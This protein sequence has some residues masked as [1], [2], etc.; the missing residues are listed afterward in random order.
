MSPKSQ[1]V[2]TEPGK[3]LAQVSWQLKPTKPNEEAIFKA[4]LPDGTSAQE[5]VRVTRGGIF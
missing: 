3:K 1:K 5:P 4:T 2:Q